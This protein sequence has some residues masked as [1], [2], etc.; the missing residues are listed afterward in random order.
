MFWLINLTGLALIGLIIWWFW[1]YHRHGARVSEGTITIEVDNGVYT[2]SVIDVA[3]NT[4]IILRFVRKAKS[5]CA[6]YVV[7][8]ELGI[9][10]QLPLEKPKDIRLVLNK[11]G[12]YEF[13][14]QMK[15]YQGLLRAS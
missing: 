5:P 13:S 14:C 10:E 4:P 8:D 11:P 9:N 6:E 1:G 3:V 7:F 15:M 12:E 2:P